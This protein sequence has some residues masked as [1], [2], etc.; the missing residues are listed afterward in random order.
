MGSASLLLVTVDGT[1]LQVTGA[2]AALGAMTTVAYDKIRKLR[3]NFNPGEISK[4][5]KVAA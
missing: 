4:L 3:F 2:L 1:Q 5:F